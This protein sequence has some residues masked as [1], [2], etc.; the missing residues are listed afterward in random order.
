ML[1]KKECEDLSKL[2][3]FLIK[4]I[5][6]IKSNNLTIKKANEISKMGNTFCNVFCLEKEYGSKDDD[7]CPEGL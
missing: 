6:D 4:C 7:D 2:K 1:N 3:D 5:Y